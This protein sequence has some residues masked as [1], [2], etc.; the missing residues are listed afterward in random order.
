M[1][2]TISENIVD[3]ED[4]EVFEL[5]DFK[6]YEPSLIEDEFI[7]NKVTKF[8]ENDLLKNVKQAEIYH[9]YEFEYKKDNTEY[10]GIIDLMLEYEEKIDIIDFKLKNVSDQ[11]YI[12][13]LTGYKNYIEEIS[14]KNVDIY[15]YS[16]IDETMN[17][18]I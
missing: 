6:N 2:L 13:Q 14:N 11:N 3:L 4:Y 17:Q 8:L 7:R 9:E 12:K 15:L 1:R 5:I 16:I 10:H 18:I